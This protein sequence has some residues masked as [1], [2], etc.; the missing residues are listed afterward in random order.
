MKN[1]VLLLAFFITT[2]NC[3]SQ[4]TFVKQ[5]DVRYGGIDQDW[6][7][8]II[9]TSDG[10]YLIGGDSESSLGGDKTE[11]SRGWYD[12]WLVKMDSNGTKEWDRRFGTSGYDAFATMVE[13]K[14]GGFI[15]GGYNGG[16]LN[17]D[18]TQDGKGGID[19]WIVKVSAGG[20]KEWD[21][22]Y[23]GSRDDKPKT[24]I[25]TKDGGFLIGGGSESGVSGDRTWPNQNTWFVPT[26]DYWIV[27]IDSL[28]N[29]EWD[30]AYGG[31]K[32]DVLQSV[33]QT[34]D[35]GYLLAGYSSSDSSGDRT[36][37][38]WNPNPSNSQQPDGWIVK[39]DSV[40]NK[41]WDKRFGT[42]YQDRLY[43]VA[44]MPDGGYLLGGE[45]FGDTTE[46]KKAIKGPLW[47]IKINP[48]GLKEWDC[49]YISLTEEMRMNPT[50]D[51][52]FILFG[53][54]RDY[55][56]NPDYELDKSE[57][58][59]GYQ[60]SW[61]LKIDSLGKKQWDK[62][63][64]SFGDDKG[65]YAIQTTDGCYAVA[66][67]TNGDI[68]GYQSHPYRDTAVTWKTHDYWVLKFCMEP[69]NAV[70]DLNKEDVKVLV[71]PNPFTSD[72][73][74]AITKE[75]ISEATFTISNAMGQVIYNRKE[76]NLGSGYTKNLDLSVL[77][78]GVYFIEV[79]A[80]SGSPEGGELF[81]V[82]KRVVKE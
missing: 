2:L 13:T 48:Q 40:G 31:N 6:A 49:G 50:I 76:T 55:T 35:G 39:I 11:D 10:G 64:F 71:Y 22:R 37:P 18:N 51:D 34:V 74:I 77:P 29:Y 16:A 20:I 62:T 26:D 53:E 56:P 15:L 27:K 41:Q 58:N 12:Y 42:A 70:D 30:R 63:I 3:Q 4:Y 24:I 59:L 38:N 68:G 25:S 67:S 28:G 72:V 75:G 14:D 65:G 43:S 46:D 17:G 60:Q 69:F 47:I 1:H 82:V 8:K 54:T 57:T 80:P 52:G 45:A 61:I 19:Y 78:N 73:S 23:G 7:D 33:I 9:Q 32:D 5:W 66:N 79:T 21:K 36:Q 44:Q 81:R